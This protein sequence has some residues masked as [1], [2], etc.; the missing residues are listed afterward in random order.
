M[1]HKYHDKA[2]CAGVHIVGT[3]G[4]D[5]IPADMG[6]VFTQDSFPG[7]EHFNFLL[8]NSII[9]YKLYL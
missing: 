6:V 1:Q 5:S 4:F 7:A 8:Y 3:C 9:S 2:V